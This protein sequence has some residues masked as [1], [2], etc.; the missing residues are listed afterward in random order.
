M[1]T[2]ESFGAR[3]EEARAVEAASTRDAAKISRRNKPSMQESPGETSGR[4]GCL[5]SSTEAR[6]AC[7]S[8]KGEQRRGGCRVVAGGRDGRDGAKGRRGGKRQVGLVGGT[9]VRQEGE[10]EFEEGRRLELFNVT[11]L[12]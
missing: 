5:L 8:G 4:R 7:L 6:K 10:D 9:L 1:E 2:R 3:G 11:S 12:L